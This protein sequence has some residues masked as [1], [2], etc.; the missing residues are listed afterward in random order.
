MKTCQDVWVRATR[1]EQMPKQG[2]EK[3]EQLTGLDMREDLTCHFTSA[4][5]G[6]VLLSKR[7]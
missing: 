3:C 5:G 2:E 1:T 4:R 6:K 7:Y